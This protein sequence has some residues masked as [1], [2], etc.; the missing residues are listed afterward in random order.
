MGYLLTSGNADSTIT[1]ERLTNI[2]I[3]LC[4]GHIPTSHN[5]HWTCATDAWYAT[6]VAVGLASKLCGHPSL[7]VRDASWTLLQARI[8]GAGER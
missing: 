1:R 7:R 8:H 6:N 2:Q 4:K 5:P 3:D